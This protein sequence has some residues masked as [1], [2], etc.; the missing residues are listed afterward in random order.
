MARALGAAFCDVVAVSVRESS[1]GA[2]K[3]QG[4]RPKAKIRP[5]SGIFHDSARRLLGTCLAEN[6]L[7][8][9]VSFLELPQTQ[10]PSGHAKST[11][12]QAAC[13]GLSAVQTEGTYA[14]QP[15]ISAFTTGN[16]R[17]VARINEAL[18]RDKNFAGN[19]TYSSIQINGPS[20][21][22]RDHEDKNNLGLSLIVGLGR[23]EGGAL[24]ILIGDKWV[25][26]DIQG[27]YLLFDGS[28]THRT[29]DFEGDRFVLFTHKSVQRAHAA[30]LQ[31]FQQLGFRR[32]G[33]EANRSYTLEDTSEEDSDGLPRPLDGTG[34]TGKGAPLYTGSHYRR[35]PFYDWIAIK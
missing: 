20:C 5:K 19:F 3:P 30:Q 22:S 25:S 13:A 24:E 10:R 16:R 9:V 12:A 1:E 7:W 6:I 14:S 31:V 15:I 34:N 29:S 27:K 23:Y 32:Q 17:A 18:Q 2:T 11:L 21:Q 4:T 33:F 26:F 8:D 28:I 35:R